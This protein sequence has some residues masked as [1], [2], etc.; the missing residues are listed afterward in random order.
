M[1]PFQKIG[2]SKIQTL[3]PTLRPGGLLSNFRISIVADGRVI[4][5]I[6]R[7]FMLPAG[8]I[9]TGPGRER[10]YAAKLDPV[11]VAFGGGSF[12][13]IPTIAVSTDSAGGQT[14]GVNL[15]Y[16][17]RTSGMFATPTTR[18]DATLVTMDSRSRSENWLPAN[19]SGTPSPERRCGL[20][21]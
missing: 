15:D 19:T 12:Q 5:A 2:P 11:R 13:L 8:R 4:P 7:S 9:S 1:S 20:R 14:F 21:K 16:N 6:T 17:D 3:A 18:F 10:I